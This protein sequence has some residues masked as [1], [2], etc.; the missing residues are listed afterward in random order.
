MEAN[1]VLDKAGLYA[2]FAH[3]AKVYF[4]YFSMQVLENVSDEGKKFLLESISVKDPSNLEGPQKKKV[5]LSP[6]S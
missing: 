5:K 1:N 3:G 2:D 6:A 4:S